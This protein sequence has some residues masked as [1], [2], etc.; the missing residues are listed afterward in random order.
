MEDIGVGIGG[1]FVVI[2]DYAYI[3]TVV[4]HHAHRLCLLVPVILMQRLYLL[5]RIIYLLVLYLHLHSVIIVDCL[6]ILLV[7][8]EAHFAS[9]VSLSAQSN[10]HP[11]HLYLTVLSLVLYRLYSLVIE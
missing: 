2:F 8:D 6:G 10:L 4:C 1:V 9:I 5:L 11:L 3:W 7:V